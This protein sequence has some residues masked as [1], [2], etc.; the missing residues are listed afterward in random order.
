MAELQMYNEFTLGE[1]KDQLSPVIQRTYGERKRLKKNKG[2]KI[3][4]FDMRDE[5]AYYRV[6]PTHSE[7]VKIAN[8]S[9]EL[10][11]GSYYIA[12]IKFLDLKKW[13]KKNTRIGLKEWKEIMSVCDVQFHCTCP[14][15]HWTGSRFQLTEVGAAIYPTAIPDTEWRKKHGESGVPTLC[16]HLN[17][18][19]KLLLNKPKQGYEQIN[20]FLNKK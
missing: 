16:K 14:A 15:F 12:S 13:M 8:Q 17:E 3:V 9:G 19:V 6:E 18:V 10:R 5:T 7:K 1:W 11:D 20:F 2:S 4:L